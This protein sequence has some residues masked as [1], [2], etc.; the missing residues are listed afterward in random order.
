MEMADFFEVSADMLPG[1]QMKDNRRNAMLERLWKAIGSRDYDAVSE[2]EKAIR[3]YPHSFDGVYAASFLSY[4]FAAET[5]KEAWL[6]H[7][8][9]LLDSA[10]LLVPQCTDPRVN[11]SSLR[12]D[13][14]DVGAAGRDEQGAETA[15]FDS[16]PNYDAGRLKYML[17]SDL[18]SAHDSLEN[19]DG[20]GRAYP[21]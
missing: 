18:S 20:C 9:E 19:S 1:Y 17:G 14:G 2:A 13:C 4:A 15:A 5:K 10:L 12:H 16:K 8:I 3:K 6:R 21:A 11:E 7:A